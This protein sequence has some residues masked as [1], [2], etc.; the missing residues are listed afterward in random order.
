MLIHRT[1]TASAEAV[2][3]GT[4]GGVFRTLNAAGGA[5]ATWR[6]FGT[7][8]PRCA[9]NG[10]RY[11][12]AQTRVGGTALG[13]VLLVGLQ[14]RGAWL[15]PNAGPRLLFP[16]PAGLPSQMRE[17][18]PGTSLWGQRIEYEGLGLRQ[19]LRPG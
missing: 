18:P 4:L 17:V 19:S 16:D 7:N 13:D 3:L 15:L 14:G 8:L 2:L 11:Y 1:S 5:T 10:L 9:A 6:R 12:P